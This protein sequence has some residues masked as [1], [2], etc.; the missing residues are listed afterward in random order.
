[1]TDLKQK[2]I[3][4][5]W[6]GT[7]VPVQTRTVIEKEDGTLGQLHS[8]DG[9]PAYSCYFKSGDLMRELYYDNGVLHRTTGPASIAW[10]EEADES[11]ERPVLNQ[12]YF[13]KGNCIDEE[14]KDGTIVLEEDGSIP[15]HA[16]F[17]LAMAE[18]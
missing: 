8:F 10:A 17:T 9:K 6:P 13:W 14:I 11:G 18:E 5:N 3:T 4:V 2:S 7:D 16:Q 12:S 1:M 15:E